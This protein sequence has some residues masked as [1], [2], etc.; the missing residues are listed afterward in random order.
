[1]KIKT[2]LFALVISILM[3]GCELFD[4]LGKY[5]PQEEI[6]ND[7]AIVVLPD[8]IPYDTANCFVDL[9]PG[10]GF[11]SERSFNAPRFRAKLKDIHPATPAASFAIEEPDFLDNRSLF[12]VTTGWVSTC[13]FAFEE[14]DYSRVINSIT[15]AA[16]AYTNTQTSWHSESL[17]WNPNITG[18]N[19]KDGKYWLVSIYVEKGKRIWLKIDKKVDKP[20]KYGSSYYTVTGYWVLGREKDIDGDVS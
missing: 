4:Y 20:G 16:N 6:A 17:A 12:V 3:S 1:M 18:Y 15:S 13:E 11:T 7:T 10:D 5:F 9:T 19:S 14:Q 8:E 2:I